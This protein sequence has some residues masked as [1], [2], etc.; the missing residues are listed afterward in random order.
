MEHI[1]NGE[2]KAITNSAGDVI[3]KRAIGGHYAKS[4]NVRVTEIID[5][6]DVNGVYKAKIQVRDP[7]TG[8][9]VSK[10]APSDFFPDHWSKRQTQNEIKEAFY[11]SK[12]VS[13]SMW[14]GV[15][16]SGVKIQ[17]YYKVPDGAAAT[18]WPVHGG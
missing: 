6:P 1:F 17:G 9:W 8:G 3:G 7:A 18:A 5:A 16:P 12:P 10:R 4:P 15:S 11:N 2:V 14:E 13:K